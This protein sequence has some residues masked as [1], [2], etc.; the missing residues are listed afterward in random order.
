MIGNHLIWKDL[1]ADE[2]LSYSKDPLFLVVHALRRHH[3]EQGDVT[4][5]FVDRREAK[6]VDGTPARF[7]PALGI[8]TVFNVP[9]WRHWGHSN[10]IMLHPRKFTQE[11]IT[12]GVLTTLGT[13]FKQARIEDLITD[14]LYEIFP[15]FA[16]SSDHKRAGLYT[17][18]AVYRKVGYPPSKSAH[19][20]DVPELQTNSDVSSDLTATAL[21]AVSSSPNAD[22]TSSSTSSTPSSEPNAKKPYSRTRPIYSYDNCA[23]TTPMTSGLLN[24]VRKVTMNFRRI[25]ENVDASSIEPPL[26]AFICFLTFE[27]RETEDPMFMQWIKDH[28]NGIFST[29]PFRYNH[30]ANNMFQH[31]TFWT[32]T[33]IL[34]AV[35]IRA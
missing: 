14:G 9:K 1:V 24:I 27:K 3:E 30:D 21:G 26:H 28:Y 17:L 33:P 10:N 2:F 5:Q 29:V 35:Q 23:R 22:A 15:E 12:H 6:T 31:K 11:F 34:K 18:Q 32:F 8:Y 4:I 25:P 13:I 19:A 20:T 7:I 16:A